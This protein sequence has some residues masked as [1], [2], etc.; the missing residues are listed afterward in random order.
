MRICYILQ[1]TSGAAFI[2]K[3]TSFKRLVVKYFTSLF[4]SSDSIN[5]A[6][7]YKAAFKIGL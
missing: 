3:H 4:S 1:T 6:L 7:F 5:I 2:G